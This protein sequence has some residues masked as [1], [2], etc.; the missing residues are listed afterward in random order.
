METFTK[1]IALSMS[2][3]RREF[4]KNEVIDIKPN[5]FIKYL[6]CIYLVKK[7]YRDEK[8]QYILVYYFRSIKKQNAILHSTNSYKISG[9]LAEKIKKATTEDTLFLISRIKT[10]SPNFDLSFARQETNENSQ[11]LT[12]DDCITFL[13]GKGYLVYKQI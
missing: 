12:V 6:K 9:Y 5:D 10:E 11:D 3:K 8:G 2:E 7:F 4:T 13:K 1:Q